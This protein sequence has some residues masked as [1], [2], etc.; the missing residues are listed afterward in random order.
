MTHTT[1]DEGTAADRQHVFHSWSAQ[2]H[3][4]PLPVAG[5]SGAWFWDNDGNRYIDFS[6]Q[7]V[8]LMSAQRNYQAN[9]KVISTQ[10]DMMQT[11]MQAV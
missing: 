2:D 4:A 3:I 10:N 7:L 6:S 8:N 5:G 1:N 9:T 11:L